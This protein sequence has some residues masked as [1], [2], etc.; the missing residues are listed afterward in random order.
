MTALTALNP[1]E[2]RIAAA[3]FERMFPGATEIGVSAYVDRA[4]AGA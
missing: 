2:A 1:Y 3:A 4:L